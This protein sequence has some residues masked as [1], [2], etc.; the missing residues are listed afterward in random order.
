[1]ERVAELAPGFRAP[2]TE[3]AELG[4]VPIWCFRN[5]ALSF[6]PE[7]A[8]CGVSV[9]RCRRQGAEQGVS[10]I[11]LLGDR[12]T[13]ETQ[14]GGYPSG[15]GSMRPEPLASA[16]TDQRR[17]RRRYAGRRG[18]GV[19]STESC[20]THEDVGRTWRSRAKATADEHADA[21][22]RRLGRRSSIP[23][24]P[25]QTGPRM[26]DQSHHVVVG[27]SE[28]SR[29]RRMATFSGR[30]R[31][32]DRAGKRSRRDQGDR[33]AERARPA[34]RLTERARSAG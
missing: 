27:I 21:D 6:S 30:I 31:R 2:Q 7:R 26:G 32:H 22:G 19:G 20:S 5:Y 18:V 23:L 29:T 25:S 11:E 3:P 14:F 13:I 33:P 10:L 28:A 24:R 17:T 34:T 16:S 9:F 4:V 12:A 8:P 1:M 15:S